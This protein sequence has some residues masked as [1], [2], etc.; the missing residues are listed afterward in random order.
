MTIKLHVGVSGEGQPFQYYASLKIGMS[1]DDSDV[2]SHLAHP[3]VEISLP[4]LDDED[5]FAAGREARDIADIQIAPAIRSVIE[6]WFARR[7][8]VKHVPS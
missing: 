6:A 3:S 8:N 1:V 2:P 5:S 4:L 7:R